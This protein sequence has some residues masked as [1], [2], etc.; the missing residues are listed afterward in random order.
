[1]H[2]GHKLKIDNFLPH[3]E[4]S[5]EE[6]VNACDPCCLKQELSL[7]AAFLSGDEHFSDGGCL[8]I[9]QLSMHFAHKVP[10][11]GNQKENA[12]TASSHADENGLHR[13][14]IEIK[15]VKR[16]KSKNSAG[17]D[18]TGC[19]TDSCDDDIL[20]QARPAPGNACEAN[21]KDGDGDRGLH[22]LTD[23]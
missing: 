23:L 7:R 12:E 21:G 11:Q 3:L 10:A 19:T 1:M 18:A 2:Y 9:G 4:C 20:K 22:D 6:V 5:D 15:D 8:W 16:W 17:N 14:R 13:M